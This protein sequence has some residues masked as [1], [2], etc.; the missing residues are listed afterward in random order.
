VRR[1]RA[2]GKGKI[3]LVVNLEPKDAASPSDADR[4]AA[5]RADVYNNHYHLDPVFFGRY[6]EGLREV[7]GHAWP[8]FS[9]AEVARIQEPV[10]FIGV[11][12]YTRRIVKHDPNALLGWSPV[13]PAGALTMET[14]WEVHPAGLTRTLLWVKERYGDVP[15]L[16]TENGAAFAD[17]PHVLGSHDDPLRIRYLRD[18]LVSVRVALARGVDV[19][20][21][22]VWSLLDN[23]EWAS[24][25]SL[26]FGIVH[27][28]YE[29]QQRTPKASGLF[30]RD[31]IRSN[32]ATLDTPVAAV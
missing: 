14:G 13:R 23:F 9:E 16:I 18:H 29:T 15:V 10:D 20:G 27:V 28:D 7:F 30:Y 24:G 4:A 31:V 32:G 8:D 11:N 21:Y 12:Y 17:P 3:G 22:F 19:R 1:Y 25:Y 2:T 5:A 26:R 6:P